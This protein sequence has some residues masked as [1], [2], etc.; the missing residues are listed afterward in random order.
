MERRL[1]VSKDEP[2]QHARFPL[3]KPTEHARH[4]F[5]DKANHAALLAYLKMRLESD[6]ANRDSRVNRFSQIDKDVYGWLLLSEEDKK[7]RMQKERTGAPQATA[8]NLPLTWVHL[9]DMMTYYAQ[10]FAPNRGMFYHTA[11][12][13]ETDDATDIVQLM[14]QHAIWGGYYRQL[15]LTV[16]SILKYNL[17]GMSAFWATDYGPRLEATQDGGTRIEPAPIFSGNK[18][19]AFDMYNL[20]WDP[21]VDPAM[22]YKEGE[23]FATVEMR[24]HYWLK[25]KCLEGAFFNCEQFLDGESRPASEVMSW[26]KCAPEEADMQL[27]ESAGFSWYN[28]LS[29]SSSYVANGS[30]ELVEMYIR[31]NPNDF[32]LIDGTKEQRDQRNRY[33]VWR[34]TILNNE[35]IIEARYMNNMHGWLPA[36]MGMANDDSM[37]QA[38]KTPAEILNPLQEFASFLL[39]VHVA[40]NRKNL[41]G[42]T[43]FDPSRIDLAAVPKGEVAAE[44]PVKAQGYGQDIRTMIYREN[45]N[46][47]TRQTLQDM[48]GMMQ[49][50][51]QFFPTQSLPAQIAGID[52][53]IS[54]QVAAV[55][56]GSNRRQHKGARLLDDMMF[57]PLRF[58]MYYNIVQYQ[59]D[60]VEVID[61]SGNRT[62]IDLTKL[63]DTNL[64]YVIG[65]GLKA[66]DRAAAASQAQSMLFALIQAPAVGDQIDIIAVLKWWTS[67]MDMEGVNA[68]D[69]R[70]KPEDLAAR[71]Q[72]QAPEGNAIQP[73]TDPAA[74][75]QPIYS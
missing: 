44:I 15:L 23:W 62:T 1:P 7:R 28:V 21:S 57:R 47:D 58:T 72:A 51:D 8:V 31:I 63:R 29:G 35:Q 67:M 68:E 12:P 40:A 39:N 56:Q 34:F 54:D 65:Q 24:S 5:R 49:L 4:P 18:V 75:T 53:A 27:S 36:F 19:R 46:L 16:F 32:G 69:F 61:F 25:N 10:T 43:Y 42:T 52:R 66:I 30:F 55:Q 37:G 70:L 3:P 41:Y 48:Q 14:N 64:A 73:A 6:K 45:H 26:Y 60:N 9:D 13:D 22:L 59:E 2:I 20:L 33:E 17:G 74:V 50:I 11:K 71:Q 38:A